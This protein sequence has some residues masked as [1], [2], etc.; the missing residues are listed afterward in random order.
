MNAV[1]DQEQLSN[2]AMAVQRALAPAFESAI[3]VRL[4]PISQTIQALQAELENQR[5]A[6]NRLASQQSQAQAQAQAQVVAP[7]APQPALVANLPSIRLKPREPSEYNGKGS[8]RSWLE[9]V[10]DYAAASGDQLDGSFISRAATYF[11]K[12]AKQWWNSLS[13]EQ[14]PSTWDAFERRALEFFEP[15]N[16]VQKARDEWRELR[17]KGSLQEYTVKLL[18]LK[19]LIGFGDQDFVD[20]F[21]SGLQPFI[22]LHVS[23]QAAVLGDSL[24]PEKLINLAERVDTMN[25][26]DKNFNNS[27]SFSS[28]SSSSAV[29]SE[30]K[31]MELSAVQEKKGGKKKKLLKFKGKCFNCG[32]TGH[33][34]AD[35]RAAASSSSGNG[36]G[37]Q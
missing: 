21:I 20:K 3:N 14:K 34:K 16:F 10:K 24:T 26:K 30:E 9:E 31:D 37:A 7:S 28:S 8:V 36:S 5:N 12:E 11:K 25:K 27:K 19:T 17:Q 23:M 15:V 18:R 4:E 29:E 22:R 33:K 6:L 13:N 1:L 32:K 2:I 35:C